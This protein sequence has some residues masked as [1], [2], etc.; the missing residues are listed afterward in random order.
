MP[1]VWLC[2]DNPRECL[3]GGDNVLAFAGRGASM[4]LMLVETLV[5]RRTNGNPGS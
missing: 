1:T 4:G 3:D 2:D 5:T